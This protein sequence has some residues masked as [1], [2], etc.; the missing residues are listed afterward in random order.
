MT[1]RLFRG[2][3]VTADTVIDD[4]VVVTRGE[5]IEWVGPAS[6]RFDGGIVSDRSDGG[7]ATPLTQLPGMVDVPS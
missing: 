2:R 1:E 4:G 7:A 6:D 5:R 3:V